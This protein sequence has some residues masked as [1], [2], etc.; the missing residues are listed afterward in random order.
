MT[1]L[2]ILT[3]FCNLI[4]RLEMKSRLWL[5]NVETPNR[6][7]TKIDTSPNIPDARCT[8]SEIELRK[9][10]LGQ[11]AKSKIP[12]HLITVFIYLKLYH[13]AVSGNRHRSCNDDSVGYVYPHNSLAQQRICYN[14]LINVR[15]ST[16]KY[17]LIAP[18]FQWCSCYPIL[19]FLCSVLQ[20]VV[21]SF[22]L[23][24][25]AI[26]LSVLFYGF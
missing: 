20:I 1:F 18:G 8:H 12:Y 17:K 15:R 5:D 25:L 6:Q 10:C 24:L 9:C 19:T 26:V 16:C 4:G 11:S 3:F 22:A 14:F 23:F 21:C 2:K 7:Q 13:L